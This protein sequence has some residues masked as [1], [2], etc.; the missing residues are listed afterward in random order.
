[1]FMQSQSL[2]SLVRTGCRMT[3]KGRRV[4]NDQDAGADAKF[5]QLPARPE[6]V[7]GRSHARDRISHVAR[8]HPFLTSA[9]PTAYLIGS[10]HY[11]RPLWACLC[12]TRLTSLSCPATS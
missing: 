10:R 1:M 9:L 11:T 7:L 2:A 8:M 12:L 6:D 3:R 4:T 5:E